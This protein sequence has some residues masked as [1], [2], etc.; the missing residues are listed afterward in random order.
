[1]NSPNVTTILRL[2]SDKSRVTILDILMDGRAYTVNEITSFTKLKQHTVS[3]HLK[4]LTEANLTTVTKYGKFRY[5]SISDTITPELFE[6]LSNYSP[7]E[8][9]KSYN[10]HFAKK[11]LKQARTCYDHLAGELGVK[12]KDFLTSENIIAANK[13]DSNN[14][15]VTTSGEVF[16]KEKLNI[17]VTDLR[18]KKRKFCINCLD[19]SERKNH[20]AGSLAK[21]ILDF[22][23]N[24]KYI[25]RNSGSRAIKITDKGKIF[26]KENWHI[27][28]SDN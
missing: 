21:A 18:N 7:L 4:L 8:P 3:Y 23:I 26:F 10:Q 11:E 27:T 28:L 25:I 2:L 24:N 15:I 19:W 5:Y 6:I 17:N 22:L 1:M 12:I 16:L 13:S 9:T 14:Y 20:I